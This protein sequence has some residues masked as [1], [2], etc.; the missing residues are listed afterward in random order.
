MSQE[1]WIFVSVPDH[2]GLGYWL[3]EYVDL[4][5]WDH[6]HDGFWFK[7]EQDA[8]MFKLRWS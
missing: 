6:T 1:P 7:H 5:T 8:I 3:C 4:R 2:I